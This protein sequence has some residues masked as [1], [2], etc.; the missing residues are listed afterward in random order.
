MSSILPKRWHD[1]FV[2]TFFV[3]PAWEA[4]A[5]TSPISPCNKGNRRRLHAGNFCGDVRLNFVLSDPD[6]VL[7]GH[8]VLS[9]KKIY[10]QSC[11]DAICFGE[12]MSYLKIILS[13]VLS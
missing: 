10:L 6:G 12:M 3:L 2:Q 13:N 7:V 4:S 8:D 1:A 11:S 5:Q 9:R